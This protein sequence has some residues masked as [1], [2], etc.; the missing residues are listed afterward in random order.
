MAAEL[1]IGGVEYVPQAGSV[2]LSLVAGLAG[3]K[4]QFGLSPDAPFP[5][6]NKKVEFSAFGL[7]FVGLLDDDDR[8]SE[9]AY[10]GP[11]AYSATGLQVF[12][13][14]DVDLTKRITSVGSIASDLVGGSGIPISVVGEDRSIRG[15]SYK[16]R[17]KDALGD[18]AARGKC[19]L[20]FGPTG[21]ELIDR[22]NPP[23]APGDFI[24]DSTTG[25]RNLRKKFTSVRP[26]NEIRVEGGV[27]KVSEDDPDSEDLPPIEYKG[28]GVRARF[29]YPKKTDEVFEI[30]VDEVSQTVVAAGDPQQSEKDCYN[31]RSEYE[32]VFNEDHIPADGAIVQLFCRVQFATG[33]WKNEAGQSEFADEFGGDGRVVHFEQK[34][35]IRTQEEIDEYVTNLSATIGETTEAF[36]VEVFGYPSQIFHPGRKVSISDPRDGTVREI[37][38]QGNNLQLNNWGWMQSLTLG[39]GSDGAAV[40][41]AAGFIAATTSTRN[42]N[43]EKQPPTETSPA[44]RDFEISISP[45]TLEIESGD[46][47][48]KE[49]LVTVIPKGGFADPVILSM[50]GLNCL[51]AAWSRT[52]VDPANWTATLSLLPADGQWSNIQGEIGAFIVTGRS[53]GPDSPNRTHSV[54]GS[55]TMD[56]DPEKMNVEVGSITFNHGAEYEIGPGP[57]GGTLYGADGYAEISL[58]FVPSPGFN[59]PCRWKLSVKSVPHLGQPTLPADEIVVDVPAEGGV[60]VVTT[61]TVQVL[62]HYPAAPGGDDWVWYFNLSMFDPAL[63]PFSQPTGFSVSNY[64]TGGYMPDPPDPTPDPVP[65]GSIAAAN[66][67][68]ENFELSLDPDPVEVEEGTQTPAESVLASTPNG[69][70]AGTVLLFA[71][72][73]VESDDLEIV[74]DDDEIPADG[75]TNVRVQF[76]TGSAAAWVLGEEIGYRV[77][78]ISAGRENWV[79]GVVKVVE[80]GGGGG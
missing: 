2:R 40:G 59:K 10:V 35:E 57:S 1:K 63:S 54:N 4:L 68:P 71:E 36:T 29:P 60:I 34:K 27:P 12:A 16:G 24:V 52:T 79:E 20:F 22:D 14:R 70:F 62:Q 17:L 80:S 78:G 69:L 45:S 56:G 28:D 49:F 19:M 74:L 7:S 33:V 44:S 61:P 75:S 72:L 73:L 3:T 39:T 47:T 67:P 48:A 21:I 58:N 43:N 23:D 15:F 9:I 13:D 53:F 77:R 46:T 18:L 37:L 41:G 25:F 31:D 38:V 8:G 5:P 64:P 66:C 51:D 11:R 65:D 30:L 26:V 55:I 76:K 32:I 50:K 6:L 42:Y